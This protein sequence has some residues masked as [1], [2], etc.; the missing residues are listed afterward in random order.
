MRNVYKANE[1]NTHIFV[2][3][4]LINEIGLNEAVIYAELIYEYNLNKETKQL[5]D[6]EWFCYTVDNLKL[7]IGLGR[8]AQTNAI[9]RLEEFGLIKTKLQG[10]PPK[11]HFKI[12]PNTQY[13][14]LD[15]KVIINID[16]IEKLI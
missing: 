13:W 7:A 16:E 3:K 9:N 5:I 10:A 4:M 6:G 2:N 8:T 11:R 1:V 14:P 15:I 12:I